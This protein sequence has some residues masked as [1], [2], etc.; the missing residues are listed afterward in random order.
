[1]KR[2]GVLILAVA[3]LAVALVVIAGCSSTKTTPTTPKTTPKTTPSTT[4]GKVSIVDF[5]FTPASVTVT[6]GGTV[7]WTNNG[8]TAHTVT[9]PDFASPQLQPGQ[10]FSHTFATAGTFSYH[11]SI[12]PTMTG[13]VIVSPAGGTSTTPSSTSTTPV[14]PG[15]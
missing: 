11:C 15:Y 13:T 10:T 14:T 5:S 7:T 1:M 4:T 12:H 3:L 6:P 9:F 8:A 2:R